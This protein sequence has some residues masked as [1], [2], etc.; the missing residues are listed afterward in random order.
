VQYYHDFVKPNKEY[1]QPDTKELA[2]LKELQQVL[3]V[4]AED[5][6]SEDIQTEI[7]R[8]GREHEFEPMRA[9]F[10]AMYEVLLGSKQGPRMGSFAALYGV[11]ATAK[12]IGEKI[13]N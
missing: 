4:I 12:L 2:A 8:I 7:Y 3:E 1:R 11:R 13:I 9:W 5:A 10:S 6:T